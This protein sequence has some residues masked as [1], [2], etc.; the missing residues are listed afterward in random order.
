MEKKNKGENGD[1][2]NHLLDARYFTTVSLP[3]LTPS[4]RGKCHHYPDFTDDANQGSRRITHSHTVSGRL[5]PNSVPPANF[6]CK[7]WYYCSRGR[8]LSDGVRSLNG[9]SSAYVRQLR[10][11]DHVRATLKGPGEGLGARR[12]LML[13]PQGP[14]SAGELRGGVSL[15][16]SPWSF[17]P[18]PASDV[19]AL[20]LCVRGCWQAGWEGCSEDSCLQEKRW[21]VES[22]QR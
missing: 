12:G 9:T 3:I 7:C 5:V 15:P 1:L 11:C 6:C 17:L 4:L 22:V 19:W 10:Q 16:L 13:M 20:L 8:Y 14:N 21:S 18:S 2:S